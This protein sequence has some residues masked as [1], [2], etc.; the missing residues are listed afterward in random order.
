MRGWIT[1]PLIAL[2]AGYLA[3]LFGWA[4]LHTLCGDRWSWLFALNAFSAYFFLP[5]LV[6]PAIALFTRHRASWLGFAAGLALGLY[7]YGGLFL[8]KF[9][10]AEASGRTLAVMSYNLLGVN[11]DVS[12]VLATIRAGNADVVA[13]Q[14]LNPLVAAALERELGDEYPYQVLDPRLGVEGM[15]TISRYP[16]QPTGEALPRQWI[17]VPPVLNVDW[18]YHPVTLLNFH[19]MSGIFKLRER[20]ARPRPSWISPRRTPAR[21]SPRAT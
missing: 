12:A 17:G 6:V 16:L 3:C 15:G 21:S 5:L 20:E 9:P 8:P 11:D 10:T 13:L 1:V 7:L 18:G 14:E 2:E 19:A 4:I